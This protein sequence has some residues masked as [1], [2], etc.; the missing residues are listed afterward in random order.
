[1]LTSLG[2]R[3]TGQRGV[4]SGG[5]LLGEAKKEGKRLPARGWH[6]QTP[7]LGKCRHIQGY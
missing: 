2:S 4:D 6:G 7:E 5:H 1:M 3:A